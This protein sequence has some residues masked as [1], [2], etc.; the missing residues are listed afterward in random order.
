MGK[1][2]GEK[3]FLSSLK[4]AAIFL[5]VL[6]IL[7]M[8]S[9]IHGALPALRKFSFFSFFF[10]SQWD[11]ICEQF[12]ALPFVVGTLLTSTLALAIS[13]PFSLAVAIFLTEFVKKGPLASI[14]STTTDLLAAIPSVIY[15]FWGLFV[16]V[17]V[18]Q[19]FEMKIGV[20]PFGVGIFT[21]SLVLAVMIIPYAASVSREVL[22]M[23][24]KE[25]KEG[26]YALG[27]T[28]RDVVLKISFPYSAG[29]IAAG[30]LLAFGRALGE[31]MAVTM[32]IGNSNSIPKSIFEPANTMASVIANEF[33]EATSDVHLAA[34]IEIALILFLITILFG[35]AGRFIINRMAVKDNVP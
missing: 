21:A 9:L 30:I 19:I 15:G 7:M 35:L 13:I 1:K 2:G 24:P 16:L 25:L 28:R 32:V 18:V 31:T 27:A 10:S 4:G 11:P 34:L 3:I 8:V 17:P 29:G 26:A 5:I 22:S 23:V 6:F 33:A 14:L 12:G 20:P